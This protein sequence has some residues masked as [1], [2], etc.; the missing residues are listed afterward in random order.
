[1]PDEQARAEILA[2]HLRDV[3][4]ASPSDKVA[5]AQQI[6]RITR[7]FSGAELAN[8]VNEAALLTGRQ[9]LE[10]IGLRELLDAVQRTRFGVNGGSQAFLPVRGLQKRL[11]DWAA[12]VAATPAPPARAGTQ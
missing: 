1:M 7:G 6:A 3:P 2:V 10:V 5:A 12:D 4:M 8:V 11:L 9:G